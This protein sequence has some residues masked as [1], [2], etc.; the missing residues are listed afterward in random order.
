[1]VKSGHVILLVDTRADGTMNQCLSLSC[2]RTHWLNG[3][4]IKLWWKGI[5]VALDISKLLLTND[6]CYFCHLCM[7]SMKAYLG[8]THLPQSAAL[9]YNKVT[10][11]PSCRLSGRWQFPYHLPAHQSLSDSI[12]KPE[13]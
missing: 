13:S 1:M 10:M 3:T 6:Q 7:L 2:V 9:S 12:Y 11:G 5:F 4:Y 8:T